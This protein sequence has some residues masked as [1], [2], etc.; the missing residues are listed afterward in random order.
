M[1]AVITDLHDI[2]YSSESFYYIL[3]QMV[4]LPLRKL[5]SAGWLNI[6]FRS[7]PSRDFLFLLISASLPPH[8]K[9]EIMAAANKR[10]F[11]CIGRLYTRT[12]Q[13]ASLYFN[14]KGSDHATLI[15]RQW[16]GAT[17]WIRPDKDGATQRYHHVTNT[18]VGL[19]KSISY[20]FFNHQKNHLLVKLYS[21]KLVPGDGDYRVQ[22]TSIVAYEAAWDAY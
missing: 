4:Q 20:M 11:W 14:L 22:T 1:V 19:V 2:C 13:T 7:W 3:H 17:C 8:D 10:M 16:L 9:S 6:T 18:I 5:H 12:K 21:I 15:G